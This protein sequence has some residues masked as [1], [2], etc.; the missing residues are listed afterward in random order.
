MRLPKASSACVLRYLSYL[1]MEPLCR[2]PLSALH[3]LLFFPYLD[4]FHQCIN[5]QFLLPSKATTKK[6]KTSFNCS[7][8]DRYPF[9]WSPLQQNF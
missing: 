5:M 8:L 9:L 1:V 3:H 7:Y 6:C 4:H 2:S